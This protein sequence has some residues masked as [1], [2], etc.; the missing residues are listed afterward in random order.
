MG[1][2]SSHGL[3]AFRTWGHAAALA[4]VA[5]AVRTERPPHAILMVGP[6]GV[7]K[8][9]LALD[10]AAGLLCLADDPAARPC[11]ACSACHKVDGGGHPDVHVLSP[12]GAGEQIRLGQVQAL[13]SDLALTPME[14]RV[15][16]AVVTSAHRLN[17]DAQNALLKTLEEPGAR[18][19]LV[20]CADDSAP[21]LPTLLSRMSRM[22]L[23]PPAIEPLTGWLVDGGRADPATARATA[24]AAGGRPGIALALTLQPQAMLARTGISRTLLTLMGSDR[25]ARLA[26]ATDLLAAG[27]VVDAASRGE[28]AAPSTRLQPV[29]RRRALAALVDVWRDVGRD[30]AIASA[31]DGRAVRDRDLLPELLDAAA[32][33]EPSA[34]R[35]FLDR[36]DRL[37]LAVEEYASPELVLDALLLAWPRSKPRPVAASA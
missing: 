13:A 26:S 11:R 33:T 32:S 34:L 36:L 30:V 25:R 3:G 22:R 8:T 16:F 24:I 19:C 7:G 28:V 12:E 1:A 4:A 31:G 37:G 18:T 17:P 5:A 23:A 21:L 15:R 29:E 35:S 6:R 20:L 27:L 9:T 2:G 10:L 14:G